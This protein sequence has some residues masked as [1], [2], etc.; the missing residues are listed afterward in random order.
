MNKDIENI[1]AQLKTQRDE[2]VV[3]AYLAKAELK[4][5]REALEEKWL[6][7]EKKM[8]HLQDEAIETTQEVKHSA[9]II[10]EEISIAYKRIKTRL[11]D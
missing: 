3:R 5:E 8:H 7:A 9:H 1:W 11:D 2:L 10:L 6:E 4:D